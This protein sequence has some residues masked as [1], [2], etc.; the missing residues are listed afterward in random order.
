MGAILE[1]QF[2]ELPTHMLV[3]EIQMQIT[4][5]GAAILWATE[6]IIS[7]EYER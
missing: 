1:Q 7:D 4:R 6:Y 3:N 2:S 5:S